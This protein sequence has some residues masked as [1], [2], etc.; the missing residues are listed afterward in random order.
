M[1]RISIVTI[2]ALCLL[3]A[4]CGGNSDKKDNHSDN[5]ENTNNST[6]TNEDELNVED[7]EE[8]VAKR[9]IVCIWEG[10]PFRKEPH[11]NGKWISSISLGETLTYLGEAKTD[12][13]TK[14][15]FYKVELSDGTQGWAR[16]YG[17]LIDAKIAVI[18]KEG[19]V[20]KRPDLLTV[21]N[22]K[23]KPFN[24]IAVTDTKEEWLEVVGNQ[25]KIKGWISDEMVS[26]EKEDIAV[27]VLITKKL[28]KDATASELRTFIDNIPYEGS[29]FVEMLEKQYTELLES[30]TLNIEDDTE[31][32]DTTAVT[33]VDTTM[34]N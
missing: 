14:K 12:E 2:A 19:T 9:T 20:Y 29:V 4:A 17:L 18:T 22:D 1:K 30:E 15:E 11:T 34:S 27:A 23:F 21:T 32:T 26:F 28:K 25:K 31:I 7:D 6:T 16:S 24:L 5:T 33:D 10:V 8:T 3:F 13:K